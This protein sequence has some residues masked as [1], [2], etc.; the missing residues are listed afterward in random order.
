METENLD[1]L[2]QPE[3]QS[4]EEHKQP[5]PTCRL[6]GKGKMTRRDFLGMGLNVL[7]ALAM[8]EVGGLSLFYLQSR[9]LTPADAK[10][11]MLQ[12]FVAEAFTGAADAETLQDKALTALG[13]LL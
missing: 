3:E 13:T 1:I 9:G 6:P 4:E 10:R 11:L 12:A 2:E 8:L 5:G 7:G